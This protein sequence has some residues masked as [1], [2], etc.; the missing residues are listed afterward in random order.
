MFKYEVALHENSLGPRRGREKVP[1][2]VLS[3]RHKELAQSILAVELDA[4]GYGLFPSSPLEFESLFWWSQRVTTAF[5][6][7]RSDEF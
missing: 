3:P 6:N 2:F 5:I 7:I 1:V 4:V